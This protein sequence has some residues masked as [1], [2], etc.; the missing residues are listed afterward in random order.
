M[1]FVSTPARLISNACT[2]LSGYC[3]SIVKMSLSICKRKSKTRSRREKQSQPKTHEHY[4]LG[5]DRRTPCAVCAS[6]LSELEMDLA[7]LFLLQLV[8]ATVDQLEVL[9]GRDGGATVE[10]ETEGAD[11]RLKHGLFVVQHE[12]LLVRELTKEKHRES[13]ASEKENVNTGSLFNPHGPDPPAFIR[14]VILINFLPAPRAALAAPA[15]RL[16]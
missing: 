13:K 10:V 11:R 6:N 2:M 9:D 14:C 3:T 4:S 8:L 16:P 1:I 12:N 15:P 7:V 5:T